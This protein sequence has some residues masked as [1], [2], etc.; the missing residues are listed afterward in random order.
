MLLNI[1]LNLFSRSDL[2]IKEL[3]LAKTSEKSLAYS[4]SVWMCCDRSRAVDGTIAEHEKPSWACSS[5]LGRVD[6]A[7][8]SLELH[9]KEKREERCWMYIFFSPLCNGALKH[10]GYTALSLR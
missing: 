7:P 6:R 1:T 3:I 5:D 8:V 10:I 9:I 2:N 4:S